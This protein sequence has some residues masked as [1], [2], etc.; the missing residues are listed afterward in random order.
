MQS[1][2]IQCSDHAT[3][4]LSCL[5]YFDIFSYPL[6]P[7]EIRSFIPGIA[8]SLDDLIGELNSYPVASCIS[9]DRGYF[10]LRHRDRSIIDERIKQEAFAGKRWKAARIMT[11]I[12]KM[13][14]YVR[15]VMISGDLSKNI[16][17]QA[18]DI[19]YFIL[20]E[21]GH[22]WIARALLTAF[23]KIC[24]LNRRTYFCLNFFR[25]TDHLAFDDSKDFFTAV[26][27]RTLKP[28]FNSVLLRHLI[29][30]NI[31]VEKFFPNFEDDPS[32]ADAA[33]DRISLLQIISERILNRL[34]VRKLD[35]IIREAM[36]RSWRSRY[37]HLSEEEFNYC[38][39]CTATESTAFAKESR[40]NIMREFTDT[41][42][43]YKEL[44]GYPIAVRPLTSL[45]VRSRRHFH[46][47][48]A[49]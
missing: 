25:T 46:Q 13:F 16:S 23:K 31:W 29:R 14:P 12:I 10:Y 39:R 33:D 4:I 19:D 47:Q 41:L 24:L 48:E 22:L 44:F 30:S 5:C 18:S 7:S 40:K 20:V 27:L 17:T 11:K 38:F 26:E 37:P 6:K 28:T 45:S 43:R 9:S 2:R 35:P 34:G 15:A 3:A 21:P 8:L 1:T 32:T 49:H 36:K 42:T